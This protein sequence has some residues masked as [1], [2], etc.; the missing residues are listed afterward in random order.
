MAGGSS[1]ELRAAKLQGVDTDTLLHL[2]SLLWVELLGLHV[3]AHPLILA[4][5]RL[6]QQCKRLELRDGSMGHATEEGGGALGGNAMDASNAAMEMETEG[7]MDDVDW[8]DDGADEADGDNPLNAALTW[9]KNQ[10]WHRQRVRR[11]ALVS[12]TKRLAD[13]YHTWR[14]FKLKKR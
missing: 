10:R 14:R 12:L 1:D 2:A 5:Y 13:P 6:S 9:C 4:C 7:D 11:D 3:E 8:G